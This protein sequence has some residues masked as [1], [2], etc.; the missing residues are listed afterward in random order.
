VQRQPKHSQISM[1]FMYQVTQQPHIIVKTMRVKSDS[2]LHQL[3]AG[4]ERLP[5]HRLLFTYESHAT[6]L[7]GCALCGHSCTQHWRD[8]APRTDFVVLTADDVDGDQLPNGLERELR[9]KDLIE[10]DSNFVG[11]G[12][13]RCD[14]TVPPAKG[15]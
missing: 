11:F 12:I 15:I 9:K 4:H 10:C 7:A 1:T 3:P 6:Q 5:P 14:V 8:G 13:V 2:T